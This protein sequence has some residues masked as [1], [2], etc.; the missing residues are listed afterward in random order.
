MATTESER[1]ASRK[2]YR[3]HKQERFALGRKAHAR[4]RLT[5]LARYSKTSPPSCAR[6]GIDD[7]DVLTIDHINNNGAEERKNEK[8]GGHLALL[9]KQ[10][11]YPEGY[12]VLCR[13][14]NY[15]KEIMRR[16]KIREEQDGT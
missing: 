16:R 2:Y 11:D 12:Q 1:R 13:N 15:K 6:C 3:N 14:C 9:L 4:Y 8:Y 10:C 7:I 5:A